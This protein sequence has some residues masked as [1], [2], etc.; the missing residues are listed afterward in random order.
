MFRLAAIGAKEGAAAGISKVVGTDITDTTLRTTDGQDFKTVN[1]YTLYAFMR[2]VIEGAERPATIDVRKLYVSLCSTKFDFCIKMVVNVERLRS[3][4]AKSIGYGVKVGKD[5]IV[6]III[7][8]I[9]WAVSQEWGGELRDVMRSIRRL[10]TYNKVHYAASCFKIMKFLAAADEARDIRKAK[11]PSGMANAA[12]EGLNYLGALVD[13]QH[14]DHSTYGEAY[15]TTS[16]SESSAEILTKSAY[17]R[18][19]RTSRSSRQR[20]PSSSPS[21]PP[22]RRR[23][24]GSSKRRSKKTDTKDQ[25][26]NDCRHCKKFGRI[27]PHSYVSDA[28]CIWNK[29]SKSWRPEWVYKKMDIDYVKRSKFSSANEG[30]P[31]SSNETD[32]WRCGDLEEESAFDDDDWTVVTRNKRNVTYYAH[33]NKMCTSLLNF[34]ATLNKPVDN[35]P[36]S[37]HTSQFCLQAETHAT[38]C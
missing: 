30:Y 13:S 3:Q 34:S 5:V 28:S 17:R 18:T 23:D 26:K 6:L 32:G 10:Y 9:E 8:N 7:V 12:E 24:R 19:K 33:I 29:K 25:P 4:A 14:R 20:S 15:A 31:S 11:S 37:Q 2:A 38:N 36:P 27:K 16:D 35:Q 22:R 21:P 1:K